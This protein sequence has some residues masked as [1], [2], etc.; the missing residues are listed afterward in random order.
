M[1]G[2]TIH[3]RQQKNF[4]NK[5]G[6]RPCR[7]GS[8]HGP[9]WYAYQ[10]V[11]GR[12]V[13]T[14]VGKRLPADAKPEQIMPS[15][16]TNRASPPSENVPRLRLRTLGQFRLESCGEDQVWQTVSRTGWHVPQ[17]RALL[18]CLI[19]AP[20]RAATP[21]QVCAWLWPEL[22]APQ[23]ARELRRACAALKQALGA[24][25]FLPKKHTL[26]LAE[27]T[28]LWIDCTAFEQLLARLPTLPAQQTIARRAL[29]TEALQLYSGNF[30]PEERAT[31]CIEA[32]RASLHQQWLEAMLNLVD[33][34]LDEPR[35]ATAIKLLEQLLAADPTNEIAAQHL[36]FALARQQR[37]TEALLVYQRLATLLRATTQAIPTPE[38]QALHQA[39]QQGRTIHVL[40]GERH[41]LSVT[42]HTDIQSDMFIEQNAPVH[43]MV[44]QAALDER[45]ETA[46]VPAAHGAEEAT[47]MT[48]EI[49]IGR[50]NQSPLVGREREL[51]ALYQL[52]AQVETTRRTDTAAAAQVASQRP[53]ARCLILMGEAGIGKTRLAEESAREAQ[54]RG[55]NVLWGRVY[56]QE[57]SIPYRLWTAMLRSVL[58]NTPNLIPQSTTYASAATYQPLH[59]LIP[60]M[61]E[62][63]VGAGAK[64]AS[65]PLVY[66]A[67]SPELEELR[68]RDAIYTFLCTLS[69]HSPLLLVLDDIQWTDESS[70]QMLGYL[71]RRMHE[72]PIVLLASCREKELVANRTLK[73]LFASMQREQVVEFLRIQ[74]LSDEQIGALVSYLPTP[75]I[76]HVQSQAAGNPFFA[77]ELGYS[78][79]ANV[80]PTV[81]VPVDTPEEIQVL[82]TS[83]TAALDYRLTRLSKDCQDLLG[84]AAV[85]GGSFDAELISEMES[86]NGNAAGDDEAVLILLQEALDADV[87]TEEGG[88]THI[89]YHFWHPLLATHLYQGLTATRRARLHLRAADT[90]SRIYATRESAEAAVIIPHLVRGGAD[91]A[92]VAHYAELAANHAYNLFAYP[93]AARY[94]R[95][96]LKHLAPA[97]LEPL[98]EGSPEAPVLP[99]ITLEQRLHL[100]LLVERMAECARILGNFEEASHHYARALQLRAIPPREFATSA[101]A[102]LEAQIQAVLWSESAWI[103][104]YTGNTGRARTCYERGAEVLHA[105][106]ITDGP[107]WGS[108]RL[109]RGSLYWQEGYHQEAFQAAQEALELFTNT[110][111]SELS[112]PASEQTRIRR[113]LLGDP[114]N[115][116]RAHNL[117]GIMYMIKGQ[118]GESLK[119]LQQ[120]MTIN[121]Q[122]EQ[123]RESAN[124]Y[125]NTG[126]IHLIRG[127]YEQARHFFQRALTYA[128]Q[129]EDIPVKSI[130]FFNLAEMAA[131]AQNF[132]EA[133]RLYREALAMAEQMN[134]R[135]YLSQWNAS[136]GRAYQEH[137]NFTAATEAILRALSI[138]R[139]MPNETCIGIALIAL[140]NLRLTLVEYSPNPTSP[141]GQR[142]LQHAEIDLRRAL[143]SRGLDAVTRTQ[144]RLAEAHISRLRGAFA[145]ARQQGQEV[146][147]AARQY[148]I[149]VLQVRCQQLLDLLPDGEI[150]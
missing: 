112:I 109:Q 71:A 96:A 78:L 129:S 106:G 7:E 22:A 85:L 17:G 28:Q 133:E 47:P 82:P 37:R 25:Y 76:T 150:C 97:L 113:T 99:T 114:T 75:A 90:L 127:E 2:K 102:Q 58:S 43:K 70:A 52:L 38:T 81:T 145:L 72:Y 142:A 125:C 36:M 128:E 23:A 116:G 68:L 45:G 60:E 130:V 30:F 103:W 124:V 21:E 108:L 15:P 135:E 63:L 59:V 31:R 50:M 13:R 143:G 136:L 32:K 104:R 119:H 89:T 117:L 18:A 61:Q 53:R 57:R 29:L 11:N 132:D 65:M 92:R 46:H 84:K 1:E 74:P 16:A 88:P 55:W 64:T 140:A 87:L 62:R 4:C 8:G 19:C 122:Y 12:L 14:Y 24:P 77:E 134:D 27:Q 67:Q 110:P 148:E 20:E 100:A 40:P 34:S 39:I 3:Y 44:Q 80:P 93:G 9:Y 5:P 105:A 94:Y 138:A 147:A 48:S 137:G 54:K 115:L 73:D 6:C 107:A 101:E 98:A 95:V 141:Q 121:D 10:V 144:A 41:E 123:R 83:I 91:P 120:A 35:S 131:E 86:G 49:S 51:T 66:G 118:F 111:T 33:L 126:H 56:P 42:S 69:F 139:A 146:Y 79:R 26:I 149:K